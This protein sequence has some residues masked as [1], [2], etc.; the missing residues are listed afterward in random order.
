MWMCVVCVWCVCCL[1]ERVWVW[2]SGEAAAPKW[3][4][5]F[6]DKNYQDHSLKHVYFWKNHIH[7]TQHL[8]LSLNADWKEEFR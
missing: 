2:W 7:N 5:E 8:M 1:V 6:R 3:G 4:S